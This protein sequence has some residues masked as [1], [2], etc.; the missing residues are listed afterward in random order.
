MQIG[1]AAKNYNVAKKPVEIEGAT[2]SS[3]NG[4]LTIQAGD[5]PAKIDVQEDSDGLKVKVNDKSY[6]FKKGEYPKGIE[7][8]GGKGDDDINVG[9]WVKVPVKIDGGEGNDKLRNMTDGTEIN[10][11]GG[12]D[13]VENFG[14]KAKIKVG[15]DSKV[16]NTGGDGATIDAGKNATISNYADDTFVRAGRGADIFTG[17]FRNSYELG[18]M[19]KSTKTVG[20]GNTFR[21]PNENQGK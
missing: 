17:G 18:G 19:F 14:K 1:T 7:V 3:K 2:V 13:T 15:D 12:Q 10:G 4:V 9:L 6:S 11:G 20:E 5:M 16:A 21:Y 8:K